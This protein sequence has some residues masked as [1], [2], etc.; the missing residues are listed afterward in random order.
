MTDWKEQARSHEESA[1]K[2]ARMNYDLEAINVDLLGACKI[3]QCWFK[4][5]G[6]GGNGALVALDKA[7][8]RAEEQS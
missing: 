1:N 4:R 8:R 2:Y 7:I 6:F 5:S 3:A